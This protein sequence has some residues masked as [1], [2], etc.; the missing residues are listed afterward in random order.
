MQENGFELKEMNLKLLQKI[1]ELTLYL[2]EQNK[3]NQKQ[4]KLIGEIQKELSILKTN[5]RSKW[6]RRPWTISSCYTSC[7]VHTFGSKPSHVLVF[8][9]HGS[10]VCI[11]RFIES[12]SLPKRTSC[13]PPGWTGWWSGIKA[14]TLIFTGGIWRRGW[15][16]IIR[17]VWGEVSV[18]G[19]RSFFVLLRKFYIISN[20]HLKDFKA[21]ILV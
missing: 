3:E 5:K 10:T 7:H 6:I 21:P 8:L 15:L 17:R 18:R 1:E 11:W 19:P 20:K 2:I 14:Q 12:S 9:H 4:R 16:W 13:S